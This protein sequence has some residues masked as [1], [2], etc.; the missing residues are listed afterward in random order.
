MQIKVKV[1]AGAQSESVKRL[2]DRF[3]QVRTRA[4]AVAGRANRR[5]LELLAEHFEIPVDALEIVAGHTSP[6]KRIRIHRR[7]RRE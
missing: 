4:P 6:L 1:N 7:R 5:C 3:Y 2:E